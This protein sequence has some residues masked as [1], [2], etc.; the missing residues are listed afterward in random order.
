MKLDQFLSHIGFKNNEATVYLATLERGPISPPQ[1][2]R[3]TGLPR[4]T[5]NLILRH[6][7]ERG[8]VG[9]TTV[10]K[11][12][13]YLAEP[14]DTLVNNLKSL[15]KYGE[16]LLPELEA[17]YNKNERKP[18]IV[19][20]EG[21]TAVQKVYDD[22]LL[23]KP[24]EILEWNTDAYFDFDQHKVD[25]H[26]IDKRV[27]LG[28]KAKRI[29]G[30]GSR[31][32]TKHQRYDAGELAETLIVPKNIF[33][34]EVEVNVYGSKVAFLNY[35]EEMSLIVESKAIAD[36]MRQAYQLSWIGAKSLEVKDEVN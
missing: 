26:Y 7:V 27:K 11:R 5:V 34:P 13:R 25:P 35:A 22:T 32:Q 19:F 20:Y 17:R 10:K 36:A 24:P 29:A 14:P 9:K 30:A 23:V 21:E 8:V 12:V 15:I 31:W 3:E 16:G 1:L 2:A 33:W 28:I 6:L 18:R 4:T